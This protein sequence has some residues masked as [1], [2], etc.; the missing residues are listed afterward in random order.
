MARA[1]SG[2]IHGGV[3]GRGGGDL[4]FCEV[5]REDDGDAEEAERSATGRSGAESG[6]GEATKWKMGNQKHTLTGMW[7]SGQWS[8]GP[9]CRS[10]RAMRLDLK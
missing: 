1:G 3:V 9:T 4:G 8:S 6:W 5:A 10:Q 2:G 7:A